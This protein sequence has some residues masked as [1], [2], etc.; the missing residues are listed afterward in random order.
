MRWPGVATSCNNLG[1]I[2]FLVPLWI[3]GGGGAAILG[4]AAASDN[5]RIVRAGRIGFALLLALDLF[6]GALVFA[7][8]QDN[9]NPADNTTRSMWWL[10]AF[11]GGIPLAFVSGLAVR[12]GY[13]GHRLVLWS[14]VLLT[15]GLYLTFPFAFTPAGKEL[16]GLGRF[17]HG[18]HAI[19]V[20][21]LLL[22]SLILLAAEAFRGHVST[23]E[24]T[25]V[26]LLRR[27]PRRVV[28][29]LMIVVLALL[30]FGA[31]NSTGFFLG[32]A[33]LLVGGGLVVGLRS[34]ATVRRIRRDLE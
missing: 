15:A 27:S 14:A 34:R 20:L 21:V 16:R 2:V 18:H 26:E 8:G 22:P 31:A 12:R 32:L 7:I 30:W 4:V 24:P 10:F 17:E 1:M 11:A 29:A 19:D 9:P 6:A 23:D 3:I 25:I 5:P 13:V 33:V 28:V